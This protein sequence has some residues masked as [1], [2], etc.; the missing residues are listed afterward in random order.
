MHF[1][2][3][4]SEESVSKASFDITGWWE[5]RY[6][7]HYE[8]VGNSLVECWS[9]ELYYFSSKGIV[10]IYS[11]NKGYES[12]HKGSVSLPNY[13]DYY[14]VPD[15]YN[16]HKYKVTG[17][18]V[19]IYYPNSDATYAEYIYNGNLKEAYYGEW[20]DTLFRL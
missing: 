17:N 15:R 1:Q 13:P 20:E 12:L 2:S 18:R 4:F 10:N 7:A 16:T 14:Y 5:R 9:C 6:G 3:Y 8:E 19:I 11:G